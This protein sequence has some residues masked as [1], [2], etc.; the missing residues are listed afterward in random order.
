MNEFHIFSCAYPKEKGVVETVKVGQKFPDLLYHL[1][2]KSAAKMRFYGESSGG[3][4]GSPP[5]IATGHARGLDYG[6]DLRHNNISQ[7]VRAPQK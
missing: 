3:A 2:R 4:D 7:A 6:G 5:R 1:S